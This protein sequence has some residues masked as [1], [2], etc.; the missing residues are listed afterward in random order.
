MLRR[1]FAGGSRVALALL[2]VAGLAT[3][4]GHSPTAATAAPPAGASPAPEPAESSPPP[5]ED[6]PVGPGQEGEDPPEKAVGTPPPAGAAK[7]ALLVEV[8][9]ELKA[10]KSSRYSHHTQV[11][12][13]S[14]SFEYDCSGFLAYAL[15]RAVPDALAAV[16]ATTPRRPR[17]SD[18]VAFLNGIPADGSVKGRWQRIARVQDLV[19]GD[20][21][22]WLKPADSHSTNTGH[23]LIVHGPV[24]ADPAAP[25]SF[26]VP[27]ADSTEHAHAAGDAR[28]A[29]HRSGLGEGEIVLVTGSDGAPVG[30]RWSR[31]KSSREKATTIALGRL[32]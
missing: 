20:V 13:A 16:Q 30:Y 28:S 19:P 1:M 26:L 3:A 12:E 25:G 7:G 29:E 31:R 11:D 22:V 14:G 18:Y 32:K 4:C 23:T 9:R 21:I 2:G 27:I 15:S 10:M 17:S 24:R 5:E 6:D 8:D